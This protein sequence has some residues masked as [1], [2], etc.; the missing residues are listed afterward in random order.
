M[1]AWDQLMF[2][3]HLAHWIALYLQETGRASWYLCLQGLTCKG[4]CWSLHWALAVMWFRPKRE[5]Q[6]LQFTHIDSFLSNDNSSIQHV[7]GWPNHRRHTSIYSS[8]FG[9]CLTAGHIDR[10]KKSGDETRISHRC[11][12]DPRSLAR[13]FTDLAANSSDL[14]VLVIELTSHTKE[15]PRPVTGHTDQD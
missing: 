9:D 11:W 3:G 5:A 8:S 12:F 14:R 13:G 15:E 4:E 7:L 6:I 1:V 2:S 10:M